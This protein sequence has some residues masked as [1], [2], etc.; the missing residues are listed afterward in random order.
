[1]ACDL[2]SLPT[3]ASALPRSELLPTLL[4]RFPEASNS[5]SAGLTA[6]GLRP[7]PLSRRLPLRGSPTATLGARPSHLGYLSRTT[8]GP[9]FA[10]WV[11][12]GPRPSAS[13]NHCSGPFVRTRHEKGFRKLKSPFRGTLRRGLLRKRPAISSFQYPAGLFSGRPDGSRVLTGMGSAWKGLSELVVVVTT[14]Q[15]TG[16]LAGGVVPGA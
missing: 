8:A 7:P 6:W 13:L 3:G 9:S 2:R 16:V 10:H 4:R 14:H 12:R 15:H 1:M 11:V 5:A